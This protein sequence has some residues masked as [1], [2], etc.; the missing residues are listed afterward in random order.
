M[1]LKLYRPPGQATFEVIKERDHLDLHKVVD[2]FSGN[3]EVDTQTI[4]ENI[5]LNDGRLY[6]HYRLLHCFPKYMEFFYHSQSLLMD[7]NEEGMDQLHNESENAIFPKYVN[8][9]LAIMAVSCYKQEYLLYI[10]QE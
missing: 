6:K 7:N 9:Y 4:L 2:E 5:F 10:L 1:P 8:Y 3:Q